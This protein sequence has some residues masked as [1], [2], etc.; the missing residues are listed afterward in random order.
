MPLMPRQTRLMTGTTFPKGGRPQAR[1]WVWMGCLRN[2]PRDLH[3]CLIPMHRR[4]HHRH[5]QQHRH[6]YYRRRRRRRRRRLRNP[7]IWM[8]LAA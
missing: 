2:G 5:R 7:T 3:N 4:H 6:R 1:G 8:P